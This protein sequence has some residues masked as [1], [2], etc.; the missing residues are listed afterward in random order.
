MMVMRVK[1]GSSFFGAELADYF[2]DGD[3]LASFAWNILKV[4]DAKGVGAFGVL[5]STG[6]PFSSALA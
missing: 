6:W 5:S 1:F 3:T 2:S 4:D